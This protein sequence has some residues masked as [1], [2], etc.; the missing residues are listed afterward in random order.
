M[1]SIIN[2]LFAGRSGIAS[3]G[4][5]IAVVGD[6]ISNSSTLGYKTSRAEFEDLIAGGQTS[7]KVVGSGSQISAVST[8]FQQGTLEYTGR[9][10]DLGIDGNGFFVVANGAERYFTRAGNFKINSAGYIVDQ[11]DYNVLGFPANGSGALS[12][13]NVNNIS[14]ST[15][16]TENVT[17]AGNLNAAADTIDEAS[18][19][20]VDAADGTG[21]STTTYAELNNLA[22]FSTVVDAFDSLGAKH[23]VTFF[24]FHVLND[25][26]SKKWV[27]RGYVN[28][29]DV[30]A[31]P[32]A[33]GTGTGYPRQVGTFDMTFGA[34]GSRSNPPA[35]GTHDLEAAIKWNNGAS[36]DATINIDM[37]EF[38]Q[39]SAK[40][41]VLSITQDGQGIG[42]VTNLSIQTNGDIY[43]MLDNG[44]SAVIGTVGM[45]NFSNAE[46]LTRVGKNLLLQ[47][48]QSGEPVVGKPQSGTLGAV[49]AGSIELSTVDIADQFVKI[50]TLQ[51]G[52]QANSR[53][54][55]TINQLLNE[56]IQLV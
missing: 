10:L 38:T 3:H 56:I 1:P 6:N 54:I 48:P 28:N 7:G 44:Q 50:I 39:Y 25:D 8:I 22:E 21:A 36:Q 5:A 15:V 35:A 33:G 13:L 12:P 43:A 17:V 20:V 40:S 42:T 37:P 2:G 23:T 30:D 29:E 16:A 51:R 31:T 24:Y 9:T 52:F 47:S 18:I 19:P 14:Q 26:G 46:G 11:H 55:T 45:V 34:D 27:A 53:I 32:G 4:T 41:N 49:K